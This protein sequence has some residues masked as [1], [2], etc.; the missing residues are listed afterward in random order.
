MKYQVVEFKEKYAEDIT[1]FWRSTMQEVLN[2]NPVHSFES[3]LHFLS[4]IL[5]LSYRIR[6]VTNHEDH[7]IGFIAFNEKEINQLYIRSDYRNQGIGQYLVQLAKQQSSGCLELRTFEVNQR[8]IR[9]Y[10][11]LGFVA[12]GGSCDNEEGLPDILFRWGK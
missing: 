3:H 5:P 9:F 2:I 12:C 10:Q 4:H 8:A 1:C 11:S 7:A 6:V